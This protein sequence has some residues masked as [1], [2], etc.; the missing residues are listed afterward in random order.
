MVGAFESITTVNYIRGR[1]NQSLAPLSKVNRDNV[2]ITAILSATN[3]PVK[4]FRD[5][6]IN[7]PAKWGNDQFNPANKTV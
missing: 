6:S 3:N 2:I 4:T 1:Q 7:N 5:T